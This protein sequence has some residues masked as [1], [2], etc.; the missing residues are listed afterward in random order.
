MNEEIKEIK[1]KPAIVQMTEPIVDPMVTIPLERFV[2]LIEENAE[3]KHKA[4]ACDM[5]H[6]IDK[7]KDELSRTMAR[8]YDLDEALKVAKADIKKLIG[9]D[10]LK[11]AQE[12]QNG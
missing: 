2:K 10:E 7:L 9:L 11:K 3:L 6:T 12:E 1:T 5:M 8:N 4:D